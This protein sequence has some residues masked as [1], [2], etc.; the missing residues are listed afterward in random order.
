MV[1]IS[2]IPKNQSS[3]ISIPVESSLSSGSSHVVKQGQNVFKKKTCGFTQGE[4]HK[5]ED[6]A[7][8]MENLYL[9]IEYGKSKCDK[10]SKRKK[11]YEK[12]ISLTFEHL[13]CLVS[14]AY[15]G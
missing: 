2:N 8:I 6:M 11:D 4:N 7:K 1:I 3:R 5:C 13:I 12:I 15:I 9:S 14:T 10:V